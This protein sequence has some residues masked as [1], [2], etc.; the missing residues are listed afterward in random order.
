MK[1]YL[2]EKRHGR[3]AARIRKNQPL[4]TFQPPADGSP[5]AWRDPSKRPM[6]A[7]TILFRAWRTGGGPV[8]PTTSS[9][10]KTH[11]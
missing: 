11:D 8:T 6:C 9:T 4:R 7:A 2:D 3:N 1:I 5:N 10:L